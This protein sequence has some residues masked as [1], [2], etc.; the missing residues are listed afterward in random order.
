MQKFKKV[1]KKTAPQVTRELIPVRSGI[2]IRISEF[3][4]DF[5]S[6]FRTKNEALKV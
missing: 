2:E 4:S 3:R 5:N 6:D 1:Q